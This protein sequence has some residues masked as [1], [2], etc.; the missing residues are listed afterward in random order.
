MNIICKVPELLHGGRVYGLGDPVADVPDD[1]A[2]ILIARGHAEL[3]GTAP[4]SEAKPK[5]KADTKP[6]IEPATLD[7]WPGQESLA[8]VGITTVDALKSFVAEKGD[9]WFGEVDGIGPKTA[10]EIAAKLSE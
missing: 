1:R 7:G 2:K 8:A 3:S 10:A 5:K 9:G 6:E 4:K